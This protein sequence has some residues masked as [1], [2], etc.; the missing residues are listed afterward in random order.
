MQTTRCAKRIRR[1]PISPRLKSD[2]EVIHKQLARL[3]TRRELFGDRTRHHL[4]DDDA[5]DAELAV[6]SAVVDKNLT[7]G[8]CAGGRLGESRHPHQIRDPRLI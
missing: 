5:D 8:A 4:R 6:R 7:L 1:A 3:P 2:L